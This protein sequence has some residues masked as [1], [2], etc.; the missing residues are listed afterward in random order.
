MFGF[1]QSGEKSLFVGR[2]VLPEKLTEAIGRELTDKEI[3]NNNNDV[4]V[5][6]IY[7]SVC[8]K[9]F[10]IIESDFSSKILTNIRNNGVYNYEY[11][12][13]ILI[14]LYFYIQI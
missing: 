6:N 11:P 3:E 1:S 5:D 14:R 8:E 10:G 4:V 12:S 7:C 2:K 13:N 9:L